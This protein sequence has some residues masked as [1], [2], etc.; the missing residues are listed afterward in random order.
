MLAGAAS[1]GLYRLHQFSKVEMYVLCTPRQSEALLQELCDI[2][3][4]LFCELGLHF[5]ILVRPLQC[6]PVWNFCA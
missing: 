6:R 4:H 5:Q 1:K 2:E 3:R